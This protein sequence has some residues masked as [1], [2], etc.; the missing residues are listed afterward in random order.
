MD[1]RIDQSHI[2]DGKTLTMKARRI[3]RVALW[4]G[5]NRLSV[6][7]GDRCKGQPG[8]TCREEAEDG[9]VPRTALR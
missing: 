4:I 2:L 5:A 7:R 1:Q 8:Q 3:D 9:E 6:G